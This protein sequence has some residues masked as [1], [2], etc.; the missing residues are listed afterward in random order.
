VEELHW[1][2][3]TLDGSCGLLAVLQAAMLLTGISRA[4]I[5]AMHTTRHP[6]LRRFWKSARVSYFEGATAVQLVGHVKAFQPRLVARAIRLRRLVHAGMLVRT[7]LDAGAVPIAGFAGVGFS[8]WSLVIGLERDAHGAFTAI[9][10]L[11]PSVPPP[12]LALFN[13]RLELGGRRARYAKSGEE[14]CPV[15]LIDLVIVRRAI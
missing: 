8:H 3:A 6:M 10:L 7:I 15:R 9:L 5:F 1:S 2:Q 12:T 11:D 4:Q 13:A 14:S